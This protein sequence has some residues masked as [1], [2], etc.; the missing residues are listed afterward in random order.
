MKPLG[1]RVNTSTRRGNGFEFL[2][3][4]LVTRVVFTREQVTDSLT[5]EFASPIDRTIQ[6]RI[7]TGDDARRVADAILAD[8]TARDVIKV[9]FE[10]AS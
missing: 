9:G 5:V 4:S 2:N 7:F 3:L 1:V 10:D 6:K 8:V